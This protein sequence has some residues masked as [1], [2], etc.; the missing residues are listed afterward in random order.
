MFKITLQPNLIYPL[1]IAFVGNEQCKQN[2]TQVLP[3]IAIACTC[4]YTG[5]SQHTVK[6]LATAR[7]GADGVTK[8]E[9][10]Y[11]SL[12]GPVLWVPVHRS[13]YWNVSPCSHCSSFHATPTHNA[14]SIHPS[15]SDTHSGGNLSGPP[16]TKPN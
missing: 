11:R 8:P 2:R 14:L 6:S 16:L 15:A 9:H 7:G 5:C 1:V 12:L 10:S 4:R 3:A 13:H